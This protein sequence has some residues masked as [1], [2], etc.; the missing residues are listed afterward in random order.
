MYID[1]TYRISNLQAITMPTRSYSSP[2]R[3]AAA[4]EKRERVI[5][6]AV[7]FLRESE[8]VA[9]FSLETVAKLAGVTRL[10]LYNQF[11]SRR[12]LLEA[13][14][15]DIAIRGQL[16]RLKHVQAL[17]DPREAIDRL[18]QICC[19]FWG[20]DAAIPH[21]Y[22]AAALDSEFAQALNERNERRRQLIATLVDRMS[23]KGADPL[24]QRDTVDMILAL[25]SQTMFRMLATGRS[26]DDVSLLIGA[27][28][29]AALGRLDR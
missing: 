3:A 25:T 19:D 21:I 16:G 28:V 20:S 29:R 10:T 15:D 22:D 14:F 23:A 26:S 5:Q 17:P 9:S 4:N 2:V 27:S 8:S 1:Y 11:G 18:I 6:A 24:V 12:G 7:D 13:V